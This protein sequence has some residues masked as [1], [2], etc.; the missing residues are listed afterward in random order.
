MY[1]DDEIMD[2]EDFDQDIAQRKE[3]IE[4][5]K[6]IEMSE[7]WNEINKKV[8]QIKRQWKRIAYRE[9]AAEDELT[10]ALDEIL[11]KLYKKRNEGYKG[12]KELKQKVIEKAREL[13]GAKQFNQ[14]SKKMDELM[15]E[16][17]SIGSAGRESD[18]A[19]WQEFRAQRQIFFDRKH[20]HWDKMRA[21]FANAKVL[22]EE[23]IEKA[24]SYSD[25]EEWQKTSEAMRDLMKQWKEAGSAGREHEDRLWNEFNEARQGFYDRRNKFYDEL[26]EDQKQKYEEKKKL[27]NQAAEILEQQLFHKEHTAQMKQLQVDWKQIG[28]CGKAKDDEIWNEFRGLMD[29]YFDGLKAMNE[30]K[31]A[32]WRDRLSEIRNRKQDMIQDQ[33]RQIKRMQD[34][35][36]GLLGERAIQDMEDRIEDKKEFIAELEEEVAELEQRLNDDLKEKN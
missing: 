20:E 12:N 9:S 31:H 29:K 1:N 18:E 2:V 4:A 28:S 17:K 7:D 3:L 22:K 6:Q 25:S 8:T 10:N 21:Q 34:D 33:K 14:A 24:K 13:A 35:I 36:I 19:L 16:W 30:Q 5:A 32:Q 15:E 26:H 27:V 23:L 11:D